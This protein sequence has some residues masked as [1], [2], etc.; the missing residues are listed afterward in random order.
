[1]PDRPPSLSGLTVKGEL[2][3]NENLSDNQ[4]TVVDDTR[5]ENVAVSNAESIADASASAEMMQE[6]SVATAEINQKLDTV[7]NCLVVVTVGIALVVGVIASSIMAKFI[8]T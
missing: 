8:R 7:T 2:E 1:M 3:L 4:E 5:S 6:I